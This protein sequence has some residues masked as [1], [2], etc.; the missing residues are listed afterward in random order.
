MPVSLMVTWSRGII[1]WLGLVKFWARFWV[2]FCLIPSQ[3]SLLLVIRLRTISTRP[4][5]EV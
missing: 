1:K 3:F 2:K 4:R 5:D